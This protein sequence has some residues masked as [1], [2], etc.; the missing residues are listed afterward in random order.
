MRR[1]RVSTTRISLQIL[2]IVICVAQTVLAQD[3]IGGRRPDRHSTNELKYQALFL[4]SADSDSLNCHLYVQITHDQLQFVA[5]S[6][7]TY[8]AKYELTAA[9]L[10][11][12]KAV[13]ESQIHTGKVSEFKGNKGLNLQSVAIEHFHFKTSQTEFILYLE[14][15]DLETRRS[16][17]TEQSLAPP[18]IS[19]NFLSDIFFFE[20]T[21][22]LIPSPV[23]LN[24][25]FPASRS[26]LDSS[27]KAIVFLSS[28][29]AN[30]PLMSRRLLC[31]SDGTPV[32]QDTNQ[33]DLHGFNQPYII[34]LP[35]RLEF[36]NYQ[37]LLEVANDT[38]HQIR[39]SQFFV[40]WGT[41]R[42]CMPDLQLAIESLLHISD[43]KQIKNVLK[44]TRD[45]QKAW[46]LNFWN[47][48]NPDSSQTENPLQKEYYQRVLTANQQFSFPGT[49]Q[50]G[51][52]SDRGYVYIIYGAPSDIDHPRPEF[53]EMTRYEIWY[54]RHLQ[55]RFVFRDASGNGEYRLI[56]QE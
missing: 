35:R 42:V 18:A 21:D 25:I 44:E 30:Q 12:N 39:Q 48:R 1:S 51:W 38:N 54:Y 43:A 22:S 46:L 40:K 56:S 26:E 7:E 27:L 10:T 31:T 9:R 47:E 4:P 8:T 20:Q 13:K 19:S 2:F 36:G 45:A 24:P 37:L 17:H 55:K 16:I 33:I 3:F 53:G 34:D 5:D 28:T 32:V 41:T 23:T 11:K 14:L 29:H 6:E 49:N 15:F 52:K 50:P